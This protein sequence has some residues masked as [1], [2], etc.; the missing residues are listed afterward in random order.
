MLTTLTRLEAVLSQQRP[1][2]F[3][4]FRAGLTDDALEKVPQSVRRV[5]HADLLALYRW[6]DG[7]GRAGCFQNYM[8]FFSF[9]E[10]VQAYSVLTELQLAGDFELNEWWN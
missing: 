3:A 9:E 10:S 1:A 2:F 6:R 5:A 7:Q 8:E 4:E